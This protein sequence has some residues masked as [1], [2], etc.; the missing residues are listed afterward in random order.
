MSTTPIGDETT[1]EIASVLFM[2]IVA[3]SARP[4]DKQSEVLRWLVEGVIKTPEYV[5]AHGSQNLICLPTGDGMALAFFGSPLLAVNCAIHVQRALSGHPDLQVRMGIHEGPVN[6]VTD[7][8]GEQNVAGPGIN[9]A[10]RVMDCGDGGH[11]LVSGAV[12]D[13]LKEL[14]DWDHCLTDLGEHRVKH[15]ALVHVYNLISG[16][17]GNPALPSKLTPA[18]NPPKQ[19]NLRPLLVAAVCLGAL[20]AALLLSPYSP[21]HTQPSPERNVAVLPFDARGQNAADDAITAGLHDTLTSQLTQVEHLQGSIQVISAQDIRESRVTSPRAA[22]QNFGATIAVTGA[23]QRQGDGITASI[24]LVDATRAIQIASRTLSSPADDV[25]TLQEAIVVAVSDMLDLELQPG[26]RTALASTAPANPAAFRY[27]LQGRGY[28]QRYDKIENLDSALNMFQSALREDPQY[29]LALTG[30]GEAALRKFYLS[31]DL[32]ILDEAR[33]A[34]Q[35][36]L[37]LNDK[38][39]STQLIAGMVNLQTG[40]GPDALENFKTALRIEP[41]NV[42]AYRELAR[43]YEV[44][45]KTQDAEQAH[46]SAISMRPRSWASHKNAAI[47]YMEHGRYEDAETHFK[48]VINLTP[49]NYS[50]YS[51]LAALYL[52]TGRSRD[53]IP[54]L[55]RSLSINKTARAY[56]NL[57]TAHYF[58]KDFQQAAQNY[59]RAVQ[60]VPTN[61]EYWGNLASACERVPALAPK[62]QQTY[63]KAIELA[64]RNLSINPQ[65]T[66]TRA[67]LAMYQAL[68]GRREDAVR[69]IERALAAAANEHF[70]LLRAV[71]VYELAGMRDRSLATVGKVIELG[72]SIE[73]IRSWPPLDGLFKDSRFQQVIRGQQTKS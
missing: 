5:H 17:V 16:E 36:A 56:S 4:M 20:G 54:L 70:V 24:N 7:I 34:S 49:D 27:Y 68:A 2:D 18:S 22:N 14:T 19:V 30:I 13:V 26:T 11:I 48:K 6:R 61:L 47:F 65:E 42:D 35:R 43:A 3:Y 37:A 45:G 40:R 53:A 33:V 60:L 67:L 39:A 52:S 71:L 23:L 28:L 62:A 38:L 63:E 50:A 10:Q 44:L 73:E 46:K 31:K 8:N 59:E 15:G 9:F 25:S 69:E 55:Q 32:T 41:L 1:V 51:N 66:P 64:Q 12:A 72:Y 57:G 58:Q 21:F 29:A